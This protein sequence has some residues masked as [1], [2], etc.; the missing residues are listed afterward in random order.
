MGSAA[1]LSGVLVA[2]KYE[3]LRLI[4]RGGMGAVYEA[5]NI[6]TLKRCAVKLLLTPELAG[7]AEVV[8]RF[9]R[10]AKASGMI[11]SEHVVA[12]FDSGIDAAEHVYYVMECLQ[13]EDLE[14]T[15]TRLGLLNPI[16]AIK[17]I[18]QA[19]TGLESAHALGI[20]HRDMKPANLFL[21]LLPGGEVKVKIL[22]FGVAKVKME[23]FNESSN[24][25]TQHGSL[26]G[27]PL[28]MSPEQLRR[29]SAIDESSDVWSL[30][31]VLFE[32]LTGE[33]PWGTCDGIGE[34]V[35][36]ILTARLP[37]VQDLAP[38]VRP[39][40]AEVAQRALSRDPSNRLRSATELREGLTKLLSGD[41]RLFLHEITAADELERGSLAPRLS[42]PDTVIIGPTP[43]SGSPVAS[44]LAPSTRA[45]R[46]RSLPALAGLALATTAAWLFTARQEPPA[47]AQS[48]AP[49]SQARAPA[50]T[51]LHANPAPLAAPEPPRFVLEVGPG[52]AQVEVDGVPLENDGGH[53]TIEGAVGSVHAV[54]VTNGAL[55]REQ[56]VVLTLEGAVPARVWAAPLA[57][58]SRPAH[59]VGS[60]SA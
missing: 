14:Q 8:K 50:R 23:V 11:E 29:A 49:P 6:T 5:R 25:L 15:L 35:T 1:D 33:L 10:E 3:L 21:A 40:L 47:S 30:G 20:V 4:G 46:S 56:Q 18:L 51:S 54:R 44:T 19:A 37:L 12:A 27:T 24:L 28:Y 57:S 39:E 31:V 38:W 42:V 43:H 26:L 48:A 22:D 2:E 36:A 17:I 52:G 9:F 60:A 13:G 59:V 41:T 34:L 55:S 58:T 7:D 53:V 32:C 45:R 16:A